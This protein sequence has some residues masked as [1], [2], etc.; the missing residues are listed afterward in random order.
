MKRKIAFIAAVVICLA[1]LATGT[2]AYFTAENEVRNVITTDGVSIAV[3]EWQETDEGLVEYPAEPLSV[4]PGAEVSK[5]VTVKNLE[6]KS[7]IRVRYEVLFYDGEGEAMILSPAD[8]AALVDIPV[9]EEA[10]TYADGWWYCNEAAGEG[11]ATA[12]LFSTVNFSGPNLNNDY[13]NCTIEIIVYAHA[14]QAANN[15]PSALEAA[16]WPEV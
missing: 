5:I 14:V 9:D 16:G 15:G 13:Q 2:M 1:M 7:W 8:I 12:P 6:A 11:E 10:W 3:E 4:L